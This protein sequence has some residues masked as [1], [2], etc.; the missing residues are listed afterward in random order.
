MDNEKLNNNQE[1]TQSDAEN[2]LGSMPSFDEH[3]TAMEIRD[4]SVQKVK[5]DTE[6][7]VVGIEGESK[8]EQLDIDEEE[9][10]EEEKKKKIEEIQI[11]RQ[12]IGVLR[13]ASVGS[14][15]AM[16]ASAELAELSQQIESVINGAS[17]E[18]MQKLVGASMQRL[19]YLKNEK[20]MMFPRQF[21]PALRA[22]DNVM[23][24]LSNL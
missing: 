7:A 23:K 11:A 22:C 12:L 5:A 15:S 18:D 21:E 14:Q 16:M 13:Q 1:N 3:M 10:P 8:A 17:Q 20:F 4:D 2:V 6:E 9:E 19:Q 24:I